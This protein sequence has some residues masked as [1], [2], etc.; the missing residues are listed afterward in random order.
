M[1]VW[2]YSG[3]GELFSIIMANSTHLVKLNTDC[4]PFYARTVWDKDQTSVEVLLLQKDK[5]WKIVLKSSDMEAVAK[6]LQVGHG[7][8]VVDFGSDA[9]SCNF[10]QKSTLSFR[11]PQRWKIAKQ[12]CGCVKPS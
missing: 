6:K 11:P 10:M 1:P 5:A 8:H 2:T 3:R 4:D 12:Q 7:H 9:I